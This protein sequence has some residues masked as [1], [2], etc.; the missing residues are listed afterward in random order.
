VAAVRRQAIVGELVGQTLA[1]LPSRLESN[2]SFR[3]RAPDGRVPVPRNPAARD[4]A[5][6]RTFGHDRAATPFLFRGGL[7]RGIDLCACRQRP[8]AGRAGVGARRLLLVEGRRRISVAIKY[9]SGNWRATSSPRRRCLGVAPPHARAGQQRP[10]PTQAI[11]LQF[12]QP[13]WDCRPTAVIRRA[14]KGGNK[15]IESEYL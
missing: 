9:L 2:A 5:P 13:F 4:Y 1:V 15:V 7:P 10:H 11:R 6:T 12:D 3:Q 14:R 8:A